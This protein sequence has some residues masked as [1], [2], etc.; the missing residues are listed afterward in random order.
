MS[1][2]R[3][4][5]AREGSE[6]S[7]LVRTDDRA[8]AQFAPST[9]CSLRRPPTSCRA[10]ARLA[11]RL[12]GR[13]GGARL[14]LRGAGV[15]AAAGAVAFVLWRGKTTVDEQAGAAVRPTPGGAESAVTPD[16]TSPRP[17]PRP[18][19]RRLASG[20]SRR[21]SRRARP[22]SPRA[23]GL[24]CRAAGAPAISRRRAGATC[25]SKRGRW[26]WRAAPTRDAR[27]SGRWRCAWRAGR[28]AATV[29]SRSRP[30]AVRW[31]SSSS[32]ERWRSGR[33]CARSRAWSRASAGLRRPPMW[34]GRSRGPPTRPASRATAFA[35]RAMA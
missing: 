22:L 9:R 16:R 12:D 34:L 19:M 30:T 11:P 18:R 32:R 20:P 29:A 7:L 21:R 6:P 10:W 14:W 33:R 31:T 3:S 28:S 2:F 17:R 15:L 8:A 25:C 26:S 1:L 24:G 27:R 5:S 23:C 35:S 13:R 4:P